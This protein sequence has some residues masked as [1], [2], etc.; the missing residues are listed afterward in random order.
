MLVRSSIN[1]IEEKTSGPDPTEQFRE[2]P[3]TT[4]MIS[5]NLS[6]TATFAGEP[7]DFASV[8]TNGDKKRP[9]YLDSG[10]PEIY[11]RV[12]SGEELI[13]D[14]QVCQV[15]AEEKQLLIGPGREGYFTVQ[16]PGIVAGP[17]CEGTNTA[18]AG[19]YHAQLYWG[20][21]PLGEEAVFELTAPPP[22]PEETEEASKES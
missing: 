14:S 12:T 15:G 4:E 19:T 11:L 10:Y 21:E 2:V 9:C 16:W 18:T 13:W 8:L 17:K 22:P 1:E 6:K 20:E 3:C 5:A 7:V